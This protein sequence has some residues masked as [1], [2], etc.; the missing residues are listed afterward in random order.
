MKDARTRW[1]TLNQIRKEKFDIILPIA[2]RENSIEMWIHVMREGN[3]DPLNIDLGG[4]SGYFIFTDRGSD[5]IERAV[6]GGYEEDLQEIEVYDI[7]GSKDEL[8]QYVSE[9]DPQSI[10]INMSEWLAVAD[11]I[12]HTSYKILTQ[13]LG[14]K[15]SERLVSAEQVITD[16]RTRRTQ[17]EVEVYSKVCEVARK[18]LERALSNEVIT[19]GV[20]SLED[21]G[22]WMEDQLLVLGMRSTF[23]KA[24]PMIIHSEKSDKSAINSREY[25]IQ[26]GDLMQYDFGIN[27]MN[28][29]TDFKRVA[30][31]LREGEN[32]VPSGIQFAWDRALEARE[33]IKPIIRVGQTAGETLEKIGQALEEAGFEYHPLTVD[34]MLGG[35]PSLEPNENQEYPGKTEVMID[36]H[37]VG[38]TGNS[39]V[40]SGPSIAGF[41]HDRAHLI[42]KP[43]NL[44]AFEFMS[45]TPNPDWKGWKVR[46][47]IEDNAVVS[48]KG[49]EWLYPPNER[50]LLIE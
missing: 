41:R 24:I 17:R 32:S 39:E 48:E 18:L 14:E 2:M 7:F 30:Y 27:H 11:G 22:W 31:V 50:I 43:N 6:L 9:R 8:L 25:I 5:R 34:P 23:E 16:F 35:G 37:C 46:F 13:A 15:Y 19:P 12:S 44:F 4:D 36:C 42:I 33:V 10:A 29:G 45:Y 28:F 40:A 26:P 20:T 3:P 1:E 47:N 21:V 38:N 49:V